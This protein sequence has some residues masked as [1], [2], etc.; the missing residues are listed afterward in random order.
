MF[1]LKTNIDMKNESS[2]NNC[3]PPD[4]KQLLADAVFRP[5]LFS[6]PMVQAILKGRKTQ[7]RR[8]I[9]PE[10]LKQLF[11]VNMGYWSEEPADLKQP[12]IK[13]KYKVG[14][15]MWVRE[16]F[17]IKKPID[18]EQDWESFGYKSDGYELMPDEK[19]KPSIFMTKDA[20]HIF[21]KVTNVRVERLQEISVMDAI[22]EG[23]QKTWISDDE[24]STMWKNYINNGKGSYHHP[25]K[26]FS[27]LW[28]SINGK[29][30]WD[31]NPWVWVYDFERIER[32]LGFC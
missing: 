32:P 24:K 13:S 15:I 19:W 11:D 6:T 25:V 1:N 18:A 10:P 7:T 2:I 14:D 28:E 4:A 23:I 17:T 5:I 31:R 21:L 3:T 27:S 9:K 29:E 12:Y 8:I 22:N 16:T 20:C 30:S 26:S